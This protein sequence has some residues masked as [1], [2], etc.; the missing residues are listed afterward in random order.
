MRIVYV[1]AARKTHDSLGL[2]VINFIKY[3]DG[4]RRATVDGYASACCDLDF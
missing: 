4:T 1:S 2:Y 3:L